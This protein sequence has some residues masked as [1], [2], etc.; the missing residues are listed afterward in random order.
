MRV[1]ILRGNQGYGRLIKYKWLPLPLTLSLPLSSLL[2]LAASL[3]PPFPATA[4]LKFHHR[5]HLL[6]SGLLTMATTM[7]FLSP[8]SA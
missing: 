1:S 8:A 4:S 7:T 6:S 3:P 2:G 5:V